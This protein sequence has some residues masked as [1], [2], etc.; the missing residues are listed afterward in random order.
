MTNPAAAPAKAGLEDVVVSSV[1]V[2]MS[3]FVIL[4]AAT[5]REPIVGSSAVTLNVGDVD[6]LHARP[7]RRRDR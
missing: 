3:H 4:D 1:D 5:R 2:H 6:T 7:S